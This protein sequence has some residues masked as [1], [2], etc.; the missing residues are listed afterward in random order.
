MT[1]EIRLGLTRLKYKIKYNQIAGGHP[2][3]NRLSGNY[4]R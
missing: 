3:L 1:N 2:T 4:W